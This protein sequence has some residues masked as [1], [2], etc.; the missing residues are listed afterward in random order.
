MGTVGSKKH[1][2]SKSPKGD[3]A[4]HADGDGGATAGSQ[5]DQRGKKARVLVKGGSAADKTDLPALSIFRRWRDGD[6]DVCIYYGV[7]F[8]FLFFLDLIIV[9]L[10]FLFYF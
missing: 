5:A 1:G 7:L 10:I 6:V 9:L 3:G 2:P 4:E 8:P